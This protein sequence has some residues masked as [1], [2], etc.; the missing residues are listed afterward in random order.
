MAHIYVVT[1]I[2]R[3]TREGVT[4]IPNL[5]VHSSLGKA[6]RHFHSVINDRAQRTA[7]TMIHSTNPK[8]SKDDRY[9]VVRSATTDEG[10]EVRLEK[11]LVR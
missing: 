9:L 7:L 8:M 6:L 5:G 1:R 10:E 4:E 2:L 11:W 3:K